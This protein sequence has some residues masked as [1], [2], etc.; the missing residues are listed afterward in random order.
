MAETK[1][2]RSSGKKDNSFFCENLS[3]AA[4]EAFKRLR[5]NLQFCFPDQEGC[6][7]V[8]ITSSHPAEGKS[9]TSINLCYSLAQLN[10]RVL[11]IDADMR[12][13][14][15]AEKL[16]L[17]ARPGMSNLLM[18]VNNASGMLQQYVPKDESYGFYFLAAGDVPPNPSELL[19][20]ARMSRLMEGLRSRFDYIVMDLPPVGAVSDAQT[21][22]GLV[23]G[24]LVVV[25]QDHTTKPL[26]DECIKQLKLTNTRILGF[27]I[28]G[29][30]EGAS[31][32]YSYGKYG[33]YG[34]YSSYKSYDNY[35]K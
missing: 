23:D 32:S 12:R 8:G 18:D 25:R 2:T 15:V 31:K 26:L 5:T 17:E 22:S 33:K 4:K 7:V 3:F 21:V 16:E 35:Y 28:N 19:H 30:V 34:N 27:V 13:S 1:K 14:S 24:M 9:L 20:S 11:L 10:K 29:A 6:G